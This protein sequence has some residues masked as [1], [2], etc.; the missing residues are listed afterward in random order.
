MVAT[1]IEVFHHVAVGGNVYPGNAVFIADIGDTLHGELVE[2]V[3]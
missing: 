3:E 2:R 1:T